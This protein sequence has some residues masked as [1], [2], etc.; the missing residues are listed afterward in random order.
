MSIIPLILQAILRYKW[1]V[2][3]CLYIS[4]SICVSRYFSITLE[5][6]HLLKYVLSV[7]HDNVLLVCVLRQLLSAF[8]LSRDHVG[9]LLLLNALALVILCLVVLG[10]VV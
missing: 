8:L 3:T 2:I 6:V 10:H 9:L 4:T 1:Q 7:F 5:L